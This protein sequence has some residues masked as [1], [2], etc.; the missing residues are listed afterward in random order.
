VWDTVATAAAAPPP[1]RQRKRLLDLAFG[2]GEIGIL[3]LGA[4]L[5]TVAGG[6]LMGFAGA[7]VGLLAGAV[8]GW[9]IIF[10]ER[11]FYI[12]R[13]MLSILD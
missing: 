4:G 11:L 6:T 10:L 12:V 5:G 9:A 7:L 13:E 3:V 2:S 8:A 1:R